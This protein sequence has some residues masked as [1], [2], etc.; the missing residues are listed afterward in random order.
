MLLLE[1][2]IFEN[3]GKSEFLRKNISSLNPLSANVGYTP[4][5]GDTCSRCGASYR[6]NH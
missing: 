5:E 3:V 2:L 4:H 1:S 6:Q